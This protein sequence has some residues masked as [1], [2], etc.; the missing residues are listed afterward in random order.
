MPSDEL[1][2]NEIQAKGLNAPRVTLEDLKKNIVDVE[3]LK[4]VTRTGNILRWAIITTANGF[5]ATGRPSAAVSVEND[6]QELGEK[7]ALDNAKVELWSLMAYELKS[8]LME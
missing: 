7:I 8:R 3:F 4:H 5:N 2:E 1:I 6:N